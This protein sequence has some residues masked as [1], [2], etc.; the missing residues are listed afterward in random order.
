MRPGCKFNY[1]P[2]LI[3]D[4]GIG[5][6]AFLQKLAMCPRYF[7]DSVMGIGTKQAAELIQGKWIVELP[8]FAALK[9]VRLE[10]VKAFITRQRDE[11]RAPYAKH[12]EARPRRFILAGTTNSS[13]FLP[14]K[15]GNRRF[16]PIHCGIL[17]PGVDLF[18]KEA[19]AIFQQVWAEAFH[20]FKQEYSKSATSLVLSSESAA[21]AFDLQN[22]AE[23]G[24]PRIGII[25]QW[26]E[27]QPR[28]SFVCN[29]Q[30]IEEALDIPLNL[31][32]RKF[33]MDVSE[34]LNHSIRNLK[35]LYQ[36]KRF[37][38]YGIQRAFK[39]IGPM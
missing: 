11:Y 9:G 24:D 12:P 23:I 20:N 6:S 2:V 14:D 32:T 31:Q 10:T 27:T 18:S 29:V 5:K 13:E 25:E 8:E 38:G 37:E 22:V 34:M 28:G 30:V 15:T 21:I 7:S 39:E 1:M 16:L 35:P 3:G 36:K 26:A 19:T 17:E 33:Q 4:Q